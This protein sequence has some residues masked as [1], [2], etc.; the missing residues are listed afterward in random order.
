M[1]AASPCD[2]P[3]NGKAST[4]PAST[5][6]TSIFSFGRSR[7]EHALLGTLRVVAGDLLERSGAHGHKEDSPEGIASNGLR[8]KAIGR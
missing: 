2:S 1:R 6:P 8:I 4:D 5:L 7:Q 3:G